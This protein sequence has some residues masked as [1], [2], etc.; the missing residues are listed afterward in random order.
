VARLIVGCWQLAT[1]HGGNWE[2]E[3][4]L[5][6]LEALV[7]VGYTTFDC[8]DIYTGVESLL[9]ELLRR[10]GPGRAQVHTK[11]VPDRSE[12]AALRPADVRRAIDR[13]LTR[14]GVERLDLVQLHWW[15]WGVPGWL[16]TTAQLD[17]LRQE[18]KV[19]CLG[20]TNFDVV[21]LR[22]LLAAGLPVVSN[23]VQYSLVD[24]RPEHGMD[25][26]CLGHDVALLCYG[27][28]AGGF[29]SDRWLGVAAPEESLE[30]RSLAKYRL[31]LDETGEWSRFQALLAEVS[32]VAQRHGVSLAATAVRWVLDRPGVA[33]AVVG[34]GI[35]SRLDEMAG[36]AS[37]R[38]DLADRTRL[39]HALPVG[40]AGP[41]GDIYALE[42]VAGGRHA[43]V[44][45]TELHGEETE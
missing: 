5:G 1:D 42:R 6:E 25:A 32:A 34:A 19:R 33:A 38:C 8:A 4:L 30:N 40:T 22:A 16:E 20:V 28:L 35:R 24:R 15:D 23:Q 9:G 43:A 45:R 44:L 13:S 7:D 14:L 10:V 26:L 39:E 36:I 21:H 18:G 29:L 17:A 31:I 37:L 2:R 11:Y 12:L 27:S 41:A 3:R